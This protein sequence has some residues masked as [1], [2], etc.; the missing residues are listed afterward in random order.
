MSFNYQENY[1]AQLQDGQKF[2]DHCVYW[3]QKKLNIAVVNFQTQEYQYKFG[4]NMQGIE[5]KFDKVFQTTGNLWI[6]IAERHNPDTPYSDS[7]IFKKDNSWLYCIG[8]YDVLYIFQN[9]YLIFLYNSGCYQIIEN[10]LKT[11]KGFL[12]PKHDADKHGK[13]IETKSVV[14]K[15]QEGKSE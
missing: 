3:L 10:N 6:E 13:K 14:N 5:F 9:N 2:Q 8:N 11:S 1:Q 4:E 15:T 12:L 7:G